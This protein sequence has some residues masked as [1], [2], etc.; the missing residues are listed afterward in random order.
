M[1]TD[2][3]FE[4]LVFRGPPGGRRLRGG[5][6]RPVPDGVPVHGPDRRAEHAGSGVAKLNVDENPK[7]AARYKVLGIS[8]IAVFQGGNVKK[9]I[10]V[11]HPKAEPEREF[12]DYLGAN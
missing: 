3:S 7:T 6:A 1:V 12:A 2:D 5:V 9:T 4:S 8:F 11:P 10:L